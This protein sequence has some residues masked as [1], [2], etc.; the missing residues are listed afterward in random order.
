MRT[1]ASIMEIK[2]L[3]INSGPLPIPNL[4]GGGVE[5][6]IQM[7]ISNTS[8]MSV[9]VVSVYDVDAI[10]LSQKL[11]NINFKYINYNRKKNIVSRVVYHIL[12]RI[13]NKPVA[14]SYIHKVIQQVDV[15]KYDIVISENGVGF[16]A[17]L[18]RFTNAK[19]VLHLHN[20]WL[21]VST[22]HARTLKQSFDE[23]WTISK[24]LKDRADEIP[25]DTKT[26]VLYNGVDLALFSH[27][28][29]KLISDLRSRYNI[30]YNDFVVVSCSRIVEEK[31]I[32]QLQN[33][34][35]Q[36]KTL[37]NIENAKLLIIGNVDSANE[38][39]RRVIE[40][41]D[42][43]MVCSGYI[44]HEEL[45]NVL[46]L[47]S[48]VV[49]PTVHLSRNYRDGKYFG[50]QEGLNLTV[51]EALSLGKPVIISDS[52][53]MP[54]ILLDQAVGRIISADESKMEPEL[55]EALHQR[56]RTPVTADL[57]ERCVSVAK[58]FSMERYCETYENYI[59]E[60]L[61][62]N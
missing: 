16:G 58:A 10:T 39:G 36:F 23:V 9:T 24:F 32:V 49:A 8:L 38:Y 17:Y 40:N 2:V 5:S 20:D 31:G 15:S 44:A 51:I 11:S 12:N 55:V 30:S 34:F 45:P 50:V 18:R 62:I 56:Y 48:V 29:N 14:N 19:L 37:Y 25:C 28:D 26:R 21:N 41:T 35:K 43:D 53:G 60:A 33:A 27:H 3:I 22:R 46:S 6:L 59:I 61:E 7:F 52:G 1:N 42:Q 57:S 54:E 4:R 47:A 13:S